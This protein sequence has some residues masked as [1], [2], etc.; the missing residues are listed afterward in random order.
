MIKRVFSAI[1][2]AAR[3]LVR[4]W[5]A[6]TIFLLVYM[7]L[8]AAVY[9]FFA[10]REASLLQVLLTLA[11]PVAAVVLF[12]M[13]QTMGVTYTKSGLTTGSLVRGALHDFWKLMLVTAPLILLGW[14]IVFLFGQIEIGAAAEVTQATRSRQAAPIPRPPTD[15]RMVVLSSLEY[16]ILCAALPLVAAQLWIA[17]A[18]EGLMQTLKS[19]GRKL[20]RAF[21]PPAVLIY[22][23][24]AVVFGLI[25]YLLVFTKTSSESAWVD[26]TLLGVRLGLAA[27]FTLFGWVITLGALAEISSGESREP[28]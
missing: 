20:L 23:V 11:L 22:A 16:L 10:I 17:T 4:N 21:S 19:A 18:R 28:Q 8:L 14:L 25:P 1:G 15:W 2:T 13:F 27:L 5:R 26:L 7:M 3:S 24:G 12:F 9:S 6:L